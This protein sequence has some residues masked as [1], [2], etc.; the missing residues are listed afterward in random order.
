[1]HIRLLGLALVLAAPALAD[2]FHFETFRYGQRAMGMG[3][4][5]TG[6]AFE[7]ASA[8]YNPAGLA[9]LKGSEF[10]GALTFIGY[11]RRTLVGG[12]R[13]A[14]FFAPRDVQSAGFVPTPTSAVAATTLGRHS[15]AITSFLA[16][17]ARESFGGQVRTGYNAGYGAGRLRFTL[18][19]DRADRLQ[20]RGLTYAYRLS[21][22]WSFGVS[23][24]WLAHTRARRQRRGQF[25]ELDAVTSNVF[26]DLTGESKSS[27]HSGLVR[28]GVFWTP[29]GPWSAG[30]ACTSPSFTVKGDTTYSYTFATSH[31]PEVPGADAAP[32][33]LDERI[34]AEARTVLPAHCRL[35]GAWRLG[36]ATFSADLA[37]VLPIRYTRYTVAKGTPSV[38]NPEVEHQFTVNGALGMQVPVSL[39]WPLRMGVFTNRTSAPPVPANPI[40]FTEAH[41][42]Y[43]GATVSLGYRGKKRSINFGLEGQLGFGEDAMSGSL[44]SLAEG[45]D[46]VRLDRR[47]W[48]VVFFVAGA[49]AFAKSAGQAL[50]RGED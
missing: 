22:T 15:L 45:D 20:L 36:S 40:D 35:G 23:G 39:R 27:T 42:D 17:E 6:L 41:V 4:A 3:G 32:L 13:D 2:E 49:A 14:D 50:L 30:M 21:D 47:E 7:P 46:F 38:F 18:R 8:F 5:V 48:R 10:S 19:D 43:Y 26:A 37:V 16:G 33:Y 34:E 1:M 31:D 44:D 25:I 24:Y 9:T 11:D 12:L 28:L 29:E